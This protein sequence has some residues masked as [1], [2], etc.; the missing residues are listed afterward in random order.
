MRPMSPFA[1]PLFAAA[2]LLVLAG[3][4]KLAMPD[5]TRVAMRQAGLP[6]GAGIVRAEGS[7]EVLVGGVALVAG[8]AVAAAA[9]AVLYAAFA[10]FVALLAHRTRNSAPC[11]CFGPSEAPV[12]ALH[13]VV[14]LVIA[15][16]AAG[17]TVRTTTGLWEATSATPWAGVPFLALTLLLAGAT[18]L[19]LT[20]LPALQAAMKPQ[21]AAS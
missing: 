1:S 20:L 10:G 8:G 9:V 6:N 12:G 2:I 21:G 7:L 11:G 14:D 5:P 13:V 19:T 4:A 16:L 15:A 3:L 18:H 17:A